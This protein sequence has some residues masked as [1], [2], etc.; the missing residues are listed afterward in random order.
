M[1]KRGSKN[2]VDFTINWGLKGL[3]ISL[4][5]IIAILVILLVFLIATQ[6]NF[7]EISKILFDKP[8]GEDCLAILA[9]IIIFIAIPFLIGLKI[10]LGMKKR[11]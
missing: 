3:K 4:Y 11:K 10:G 9:G 8:T 2:Q 1:K 5:C 6:N 7:S